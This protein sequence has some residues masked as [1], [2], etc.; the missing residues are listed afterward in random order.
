M[1]RDAN[2]DF[3]GPC[4]QGGTQGRNGGN[5]DAQWTGPEDARQH[6]GRFG[7]FGCGPQDGLKVR[8]DKWE[9][10]PGV[11]AF[12]FKNPLHCSCNPRYRTQRIECLGRV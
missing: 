10:F 11:P 6:L 7:P 12:Y 2:G 4:V 1:R 5:D 3:A 8:R 9:R